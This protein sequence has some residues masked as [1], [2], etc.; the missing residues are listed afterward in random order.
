M[1]FYL[2]VLV[3]LINNTLVAQRKPDFEFSAGMGFGLSEKIPEDNLSN[4]EI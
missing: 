3:R 4:A 1:F 2:C